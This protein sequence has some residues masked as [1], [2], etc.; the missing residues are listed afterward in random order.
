MVDYVEFPI[1][2][3]DADCEF[4]KYCRREW[5]HTMKWYKKASRECFRQ[6]RARV[7]KARLERERK[8]RECCPNGH[9]EDDEE[10]NQDKYRDDI[11]DFD[12]YSEDLNQ[13]ADDA[14]DLSAHS[15]YSTTSEINE[16]PNDV[17][18][19]KKN[20]KT[21]RLR[22]QKM[23]EE[24]ENHKADLMEGIE[25]HRFCEY[26]PEN[27]WA[28]QVTAVTFD[29]VETIELSDNWRINLRLGY[30]PMDMK[31]P[32]EN[33]VQMQV[34]N[35]MLQHTRRGVNANQYLS[36]LV[37]SWHNPLFPSV[38]EEAEE[39]IKELYDR[40]LPAFFY[41]RKLI[42][43][44]RRVTMEKVDKKVR[45]EPCWACCHDSEDK[46]REA[47]AKKLDGRAWELLKSAKALNEQYRARPDLYKYRVCIDGEFKL[48]Q[49]RQSD[50]DPLISGNILIQQTEEFD[51]T[52]EERNIR[53]DI[54]EKEK[55]EDNASFD[56][57]FDTKRE[58]KQY[59]N[60]CGTSRYKF[61][62]SENINT[63]PHWKRRGLFG[64]VCCHGHCSVIIDMISEEVRCLG[65]QALQRYKEIHKIDNKER[66]LLGYDIP[67][68]L[69]KWIKANWDVI[70]EELFK[71]VT[72]CGP[73]FHIYTHEFRCW[74]KRSIRLIINSG[75]CDLE[76]TERTWSWLHSGVA[77]SSIYMG[78]QNREDTIEFAITSINS[79]TTGMLVRNLVK[80]YARVRS[81]LDSSTLDEPVD[82]ITKE[83]E[84][85]R[86]ELKASF[87]SMQASMLTRRMKHADIHL[88]K[89]LK[90]RLTKLIDD[91]HHPVMDIRIKELFDELILRTRKERVMEEFEYIA[92]S[93]KRILISIAHAALRV[94]RELTDTMIFNPELVGRIGRLRWEMDVLSKQ[95]ARAKDSFTG[96]GLLK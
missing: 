64:L 19:R 38:V 94:E 75:L 46:K 85:L 69:E 28:K 44:I 74:I 13:Y 49:R 10:E 88:R 60:Q 22:R 8:E 20:R 57:K 12:D 70:L 32:L 76:N 45:L 37:Y 14:D 90:D 27:A 52:K 78:R 40:M 50:N 7:R 33:V 68:Q 59:A 63:N 72:I 53:H 96:I 54:K 58:T 29:G 2:I 86:K 89:R 3:G 61:G 26:E 23:L 67:C 18:N 11:M 43:E 41:Y 1:V 35:L 36:S 51:F 9:K 31:C 73:A 30:F 15:G 4:A 16:T 25:V 81:E 21:K 56:A 55:R 71:E 48:G 93:G 92:R 24:F 83:I 95:F 77:R 39:T 42:M 6:E 17:K 34:L 65:A 47:E 66:I 91:G 62:K 82:E 84:R 5:Q 79:R 80:L 87:P